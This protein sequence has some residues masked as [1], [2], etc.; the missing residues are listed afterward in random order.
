MKGNNTLWH[1]KKRCGWNTGLQVRFL[2]GASQHPRAEKVIGH[3]GTE[4]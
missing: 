3:F 4:S 1:T 2:H